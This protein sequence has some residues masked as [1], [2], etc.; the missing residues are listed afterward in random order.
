ME[1][2]SF[3]QRIFG[4]LMFSWYF[5][6]PEIAEIQKGKFTQTIVITLLSTLFATRLDIQYFIANYPQRAI[7]IFIAGIIIALTFMNHSSI[8][9]ENRID[10]I[11]RR[12]RKYILIYFHKILDWIYFSTPDKYIEEVEKRTLSFYQNNF[13]LL[14]FSILI[15]D[16]FTLK[17]LT[18][19]FAIVFLSTITLYGIL[20]FSRMIVKYPLR[21]YLGAILFPWIVFFSVGYICDYSGIQTPLLEDQYLVSYFGLD[22]SDWLGSTLKVC[23]FFSMYVLFSLVLW[24][25]FSMVGRF[26]FKYIVRSLKF[27]LIKIPVFYRQKKKEKIIKSSL[28]V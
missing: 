23:I 11:S 7:S 8:L 16:H 20:S 9:R 18:S 24:T 4:V 14:I 21:I 2:L 5:F 17:F 3:T 27:L 6:A 15:F 25:A 10:K 13:R 26:I 12:L 19:S 1:E 22:A 28:Q